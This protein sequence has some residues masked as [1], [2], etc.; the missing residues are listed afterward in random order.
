MY[1]SK[2]G[3]RCRCRID[4]FQM[5]RPAS[6]NRVAE[7]QSSCNSANVVEIQANSSLDTKHKPYRWLKQILHKNSLFRHNRLSTI[8]FSIKVAESGNNHLSKLHYRF[9]RYTSLIKTVQLESLY[10]QSYDGLLKILAWKFHKV[11]LQEYKEYA[12]KKSGKQTNGHILGYPDIDWQYS[13][14]PYASGQ[15]GISRGIFLAKKI[16]RDNAGGL[17]AKTIS[18]D[19]P[20]YPIACLSRYISIYLFLCG[21][22]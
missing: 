4:H 3:L 22:T 15:V 9:Q 6:S 13:G 2:H 8:F 11:F 16:S 18:Q 14:M 7:K 5:Y 12:K 19:A 20:R 17:F 1:F 21:Y 10:L